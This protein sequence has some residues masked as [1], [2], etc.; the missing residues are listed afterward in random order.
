MSPRANPGQLFP[1][2]EVPEGETPDRH[3]P[4]A[5]AVSEQERPTDTWRISGWPVRVHA[6][7]QR[8]GDR[9]RA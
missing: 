4:Q 3:T 6:P 5:A 9:E 1:D 7:Y 2:L 8:D